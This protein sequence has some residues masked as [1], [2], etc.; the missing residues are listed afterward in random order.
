MNNVAKQRSKAP[1]SSKLRLKELT[2]RLA[3]A[4][5]SKTVAPPAT[6]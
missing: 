2:S 3:I 4:M 5:I 6:S 1:Q